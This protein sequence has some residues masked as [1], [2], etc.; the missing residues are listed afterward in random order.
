M[1]VLDV[2]E[3]VFHVQDARVLSLYCAIIIR[4]G[5]ISMKVECKIDPDEVEMTLEEFT[6]QFYL[7]LELAVLPVN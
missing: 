6:Y 5:G 1:A 4:E 2:Q 3:V 7:E